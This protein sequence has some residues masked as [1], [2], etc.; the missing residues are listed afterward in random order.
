MQTTSFPSVPHSTPTSRP[1]SFEDR[2]AGVTA[3]CVAGND[4]PVVGTVRSGAAAPVAE[5]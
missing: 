1:R 2:A 4:H 3:A 5:E